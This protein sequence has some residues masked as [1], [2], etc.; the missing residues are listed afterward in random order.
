MQKDQRYTGFLPLFL[1][2]L[3][4]RHRK[5]STQVTFC[6]FTGH[7]PWATYQARQPRSLARRVGKERANTRPCLLRCFEK[8]GQRVPMSCLHP[9]Q[10]PSCPRPFQPREERKWDLNASSRNGLGAMQGKACP[11]SWGAYGVRVPRKEFSSFL[12]VLGS[13]SFPSWL[14]MQVSKPL[15]FFLTQKIVQIAELKCPVAFR[16]ENTGCAHFGKT[17]HLRVGEQTSR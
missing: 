14:S 4:F 6:K 5:H 9:K 13:K 8:P 16:L 3:L 12:W 10:G 11:A 1:C 7:Q 2:F 17:L 15:G